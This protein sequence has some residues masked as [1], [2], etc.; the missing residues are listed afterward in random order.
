MISTIKRRKH[1][2]EKAKLIFTRNARGQQTMKLDISD[3][4]AEVET[5][6]GLGLLESKIHKLVRW[7]NAMGVRKSSSLVVFPWLLC[8]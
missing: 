5:V 8:L 4:W 3:S 7:E 1:I 6:G 2:S